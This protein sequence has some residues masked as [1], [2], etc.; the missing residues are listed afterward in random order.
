VSQ[1][2]PETGAEQL[3]IPR[4]LPVLPLRDLVVY[5]FIILPLS[6]SRDISIN[7]VDQALSGSRMIL[8]LSQKDAEV[9]DPAPEDLYAV[10]T[11][12]VIMR[13]L[14][15]PDERVRVLVQ[16]VA[17]AQVTGFQKGLPYLSASLKRVVESQ[18]D[19]ASLQQQAMM[20]SVKKSLESA[21]D[22]GR[23][24]SSEVM[25]IANN[26]EDPGRLADLAASNLELE[27]KDA[28]DILQVL[29]PLER[30]KKVHTLLNKELQLLT[31][32]QEINTVAREEMDRSQRE[33]F[34]RQQLK[35]IQ[36]ELGEGNDLAEEML[37]LREKARAAE[38]PENVMKEVDT[39]IRKL[40]RIHPESGETAMIRSYLDWL[41]EIPWSRTTTDNLDMSE[42]G[43]I[44]DED[45][46]GLEAIKER[47]LEFLAVRKLNPK[48]RG[49][50]LCFVGPPGVGK[51]SLGRSIARALGRKFVRLSLGGVRDEAEIRG[52]R[53]T[54]IGAMPG[55]IAQGLHQAGTSN[56]VFL[57]D[58]IDK[59]GADH[60]G[61]PS[62]ALLEVLDPEQNHAFRDHYLGLPLDLS[63]VMFLATANLIEPVQPAFRDRL[64]VIQLS[65]Y[66][67]EE[68]IEIARQHIIPRQ[69]Q[70]NGLTP[71]KIVFSDAS[72]RRVIN[73]YTR[74][75]GLRNLEREISSICRKVARQVAAGKKGCTRVGETHVE[76]LLGVPRIADAQERRE[77]RV[78]V[79]VGL[80][81]TATGG[82]ML[83][84]EASIM[85]GRGRLILT[86]HLGDVMKESAQAALSYARAHAEELGLTDEAFTSH[87]IHVHVPE[88]AIPKDG[89]SAGITMA[90][91]LVSALS[92]QAVR[93]DL[94][95]TGEITLRGDVLAVG[96]IKEKVLAARR[97]GI[98]TV[99]LPMSSRRHVEEIPSDLRH[100][101][102]FV[103]VDEVRRV[104]ETALVS[105][106]PAA[107]RRRAGGKAAPRAAARRSGA[108]RIR[109]GRPGA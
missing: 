27:V 104:L 6:I 55:R 99:I 17:R 46:Y 15:L 85:P 21:S 58:E 16:G 23:S 45:H 7:A 82:E 30:L 48:M 76:K 93:G 47:I 106:K 91:A 39:Q 68:K 5:P 77:D 28:Q 8:L 25:V 84:V 51:T 87:D 103:L 54:Y 11:V 14:K 97:A 64:E 61:D 109:K 43:R 86:G 83:Y 4:K 72:V 102:E 41:V 74:E 19:K 40:E 56:P 38:V 81:W 80:A 20:R 24:I 36:L 31:M 101:M 13:L 3:R 42:A 90:T 35:A 96:G 34:L 1:P 60:R 67:E 108:V 69:V 29:D 2:T 89:P 105:G 66:T 9:D 26:L 33:F 98:R 63:R 59:I 10:G 50:I 22:M 12:G 53:R 107:R 71:R 70:E 73:G 44:L 62:A 78:G 32:Q 75:A 94:A 65:G 100:D 37:A 92:S 18:A 79:A 49:P 95:M 52:H 88:G 57:L